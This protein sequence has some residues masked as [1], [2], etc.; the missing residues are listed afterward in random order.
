MNI[1]ERIEKLK[2]RNEYF[3]DKD[4]DLCIKSLQALKIIYDLFEC[5]SDDEDNKNQDN[6]RIKVGDE[7]VSSLGTKL[8][9]TAMG[10]QDGYWCCIDK[11]GVVSIITTQ[12][13]KDFN[14]H[15]TGRHF[16]Q[17]ND[18]LND[19]WEWMD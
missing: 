17:M 11:K 10:G 2:K 3:Y 5:D 9:I 16:Y 8:I 1:E 6:D 15:K 19:L 14:W 13:I 4:I 12:N 18:L 7:V